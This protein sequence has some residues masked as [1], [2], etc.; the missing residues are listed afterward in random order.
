MNLRE[1]LARITETSPEILGQARY[2]Q[3]PEHLRTLAADRSIELSTE[4]AH[5]LFEFV[6]PAA[7]SLSDEEL[8]AVAG[9]QAH[10][11]KVVTEQC[12]KCGSDASVYAIGGNPV[13]TAC[14]NCFYMEYF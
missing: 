7:D 10:V 8:A 4:E 11:G 9:G 5:A 12:P 2:C 6:S 3:T 1:L 14:L 13:W